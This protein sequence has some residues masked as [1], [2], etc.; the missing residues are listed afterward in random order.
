LC[1]YK[2]VS[3]LKREFVVIFYNILIVLTLEVHKYR[4][5]K[6]LFQLSP[7]LFFY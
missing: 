1:I 6:V 2:D 5:D 7:W 4:T 3:I